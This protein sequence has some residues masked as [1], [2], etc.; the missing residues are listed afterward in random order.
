MK[1]ILYL[2]LVVVSAASFGTSAHAQKEYRDWYPEWT[3]QETGNPFEKR[4][5][6]YF[7]EKPIPKEDRSILVR[8]SAAIEPLKPFDKPR[9]GTLSDIQRM[10]LKEV[11]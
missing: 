6:I 11:R 3:E 8:P 10:Q 4:K 1:K 7:D 9:S 2:A 5:P